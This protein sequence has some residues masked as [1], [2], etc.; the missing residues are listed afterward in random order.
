MKKL[1]FTILLVMPLFAQ[2][3]S[4]L[5]TDSS[6]KKTTSGWTIPESATPANTNGKSSSATNTRNIK[7]GYPGNLKEDPK[8]LEGAVPQDTDGNVIFTLDLDI[9]GKTAN[10]I[11]ETVYR[12]LDQLTKEENQRLS[13]VA[14]INT[15]EH[16]IAAKYSEWLEFTR[17][18]L[19]LDRTEFNY[20]LIAKCSDNHLKLTLGRI[21][22]NYEKG[23]ST[24][25]STNAE[26]WITDKIALNKKK[27]G[28]RAMS[29]KFRRK[30]I[31]RKDQIFSQVKALFR[32]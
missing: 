14:L 8:Y 20:T 21:F 19:S 27:N 1:F 30:T 29:A 31:D 16:I 9:A 10:Q 12:Y 24:S 11:Y 28:L 4:A 18:F 17:T 22:Y 32:P 13:R 6:T 5:P 3:Q 23:R 15:D 25:L 2:A 26:K 7:P